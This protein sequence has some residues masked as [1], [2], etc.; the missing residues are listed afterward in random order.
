MNAVRPV[1]FHD[2]PLSEIPTSIGSKPSSGKGTKEGGEQTMR[3]IQELSFYSELDGE[4][5]ECG[6]WR[7]DTF[8]NCSKAQ[9]CVTLWLLLWYD[10]RDKIEVLW[11]EFLTRSCQTLTR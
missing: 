4:K 7:S 10:R 2:S 6:L 3:L 5:L 8:A 11:Q 1:P 9:A